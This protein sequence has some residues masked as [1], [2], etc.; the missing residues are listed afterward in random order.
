MKFTSKISL[1]IAIALLISVGGVYAAWTYIDY[2]FTE[3]DM[4]AR[5]VGVVLAAS[6][7]STNTTAKSGVITVEG[8]RNSLEI[9]QDTTENDY[10]GKLLWSS[11]SPATVKYT[12]NRDVTSNGDNETAAPDKIDILV[13]V[14][15][16]G[17]NTFEDQA[18]L[19]FDDTMEGLT[20]AGN[21]ATYTL[22]DVDGNGKE[23]DLAHAI[24]LRE[25]FKLPTK[26]QYDACA[27][28]FRTLSVSVTFEEIV[29]ANP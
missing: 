9:D 28:V 1:V 8:G 27:E 13:T 18:I 10:S 26:A 16:N 3:A 4:V 7:V 6:S 15:I 19:V 24:L 21:V 12:P 29:S 14:T 22:E 23:F 5:D 2:M 17:T 11:N 20:I 25:G